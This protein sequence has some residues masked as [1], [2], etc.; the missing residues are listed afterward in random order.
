MRR[1]VQVVWSRTDYILG[2][3]SRLFKNVAVRDPRHN[4]DHYMVLG[5]LPSA[6]LS[7]TKR[8][9]GGAKALAGEATNGTLT[10]G[11]SICGSTE[12]RTKT[13]TAGSETKRLDLGGN[14]A[15]HQRESLHAPGPAVQEGGQ[16]E[17][18]DGDQ[19]ETRTGQE[20]ED[21]G[22]GGGGGGYDEGGATPLG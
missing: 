11:H 15:T 22:G 18:G 5:C 6:P 17:V 20:E 12:S 19:G 14:V 8:Y 16:A 2:T 21:G 9:L 1:K 3:D 13:N 4:S 10:D 7:A